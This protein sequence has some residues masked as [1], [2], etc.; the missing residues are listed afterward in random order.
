MTGGVPQ[1]L[2]VENEEVRVR[3]VVVDKLHPNF[4]LS[5]G[6]RAQ[7]SVLAITAIVRV[8]STEFGLVLLNAVELFDLVVTP[9]AALVAG[10]DELVVF[11][12]DVLN[13][14]MSTFWATGHKSLKTGICIR[15]RSLLEWKKRHCLWLCCVLI[16]QG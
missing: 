13:G 11:I 2:I 9:V 4:I 15:R 5:M 3:L 8:V 7:H 10:T 6:K 16:S 12:V 14:L 1:G